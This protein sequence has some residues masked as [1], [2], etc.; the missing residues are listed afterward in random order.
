MQTLQYFTY[1]VTITDYFEDSLESLVI[2]NR[3]TWNLFPERDIKR[4]LFQIL[5]A[6]RP[7]HNRSK[8]HGGI[9][10]ST[11]LISRSNNNAYL[12][13]NFSSNFGKNGFKAPELY[14]ALEYTLASDIWSIGVILYQL[15]TL[16]PPFSTV[17]DLYSYI[18][19][20]NVLLINDDSSNSKY[21]NDLT[22]II[23]QCLTPHP[24][25]RVT[26]D[27]LLESQ[28]IQDQYLH[29]INLLIY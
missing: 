14:D 25:D 7:N 6:I 28:Y 27:G 22:D 4:W 8:Y 10:L 3:K 11:V 12:D 16:T 13:Y 29:G 9:S 1:L 20:P 5:T 23:K 18:F 19:N 21:S 2:K 15:T 26:V 17:E 24:I